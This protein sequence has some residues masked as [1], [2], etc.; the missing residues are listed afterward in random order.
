[1]LKSVI[2]IFS[3]TYAYAILRYHLGKNIPLSEFLYILN[4]AFSWTAFT[5]ITWSILPKQFFENKKTNR[6]FFGISGYLIASLHIILNI[7]L[8]NNIRFPNFYADSGAWNLNFY[9]VSTAGL[10]SF[11]IFSIVFLVSID[12]WKVKNKETILS[13]GFFGVLI[14]L[15]HPFFLGYQRWF[16]INSWPFY[17][18]PITMLAFLFGILVLL[19]KQILNLK[20]H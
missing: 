17:L 2:L 6:K 4:K 15:F 16:D 18:P 1:M 12:F 11:I 13:L 9:L 8:L 3:F 10:I 14:N 5:L 19:F 20:K 7:I